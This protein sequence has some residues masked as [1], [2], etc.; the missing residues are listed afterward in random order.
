MVI[1]CVLKEMKC[2]TTIQ[3]NTKIYQ[4]GEHCI[5]YSEAEPID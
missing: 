1:L 3:Q 2:S 4:N 5:F